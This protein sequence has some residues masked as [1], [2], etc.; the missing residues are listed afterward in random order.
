MSY[1]LSNLEPKAVFK[2]FEDLS[3][4][5]RESKNEK[6]VSDFLVNFG[7]KLNLETIQDKALNVIIRKSATKGYENAPIVMLQSHMDMVAEK[8]QNSN[9]DF[10]KDPI[11]LI[12]KDDL[13]YANQ[14]TLGADDGIGAAMTMALLE[15]T[16]IPHP[17]IE[18]LFTTDEEQGMVGVNALDGNLLKSKYV[19]NLDSEEEGFITVGCAGGAD[20]IMSLDVK[21]KPA[22]K[23]FTTYKITVSDLTGGHSGSDIQLQ[24]GNA[25]KLIMRLLNNISCDY[26]LAFIDGG[27]KRNAIARDSY[28]VVSFDSSNFKSVKSEIDKLAEAIHQEIVVN[29][30]N[31]K[32]EIIECEKVEKTYTDDVKNKIINLLITAPHGIISMNLSLE[33]AV[34]TSVNLA[35]IKEIDEKIT[36]VS[37]M[38]SSSVSKMNALKAK[39]LKTAELAG[40]DAHIESEYPG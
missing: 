8:T 14:T 22:N 30:P 7:K 9:H 3:R 15:S 40:F 38:R 36:V 24:R 32:V 4:I 19:I 17:E 1:K 10:L 29:D 34:E 11:E 12:I 25:N 13:I 23:D 31:L 2:N 21:H 16:D 37:M 6:E 18:A 26:D 20:C 28:A 35:L 39:Y 27:S 33:N 5:P